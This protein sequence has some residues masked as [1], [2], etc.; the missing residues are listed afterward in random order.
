[1]YRDVRAAL[2][3]LLG[4]TLCFPT[5]AATTNELISAIQAVESVGKN[6]SQA[7]NAIQELNSGDATTLVPILNAMGTANPLALNWLQGAFESVASRSLVAGN[8]PKEQ[9]ET[10]VVERSNNAQARRLAYEWLVKVDPSAE[11]RLIP[12]M[13]DDPSTYLRRD[14][15]AYAIHQAKSAEA[16]QQREFWKVALNGAVDEDQVKEIA[17]ALKKLDSPV[18]LI[19]HFGYLMDWKLIG[20]F[21]NIEMKGFNVVYPP[22]NEIDLSAEYQGLKG[23]VKW[24][25]FHSDDP[26][27]LFDIAKLTESHKGAIDYAYTTFNSS[28]ERDLEF[29]LSIQNAF[30][31]WVNGELLFAREEYHRGMHFDQYIVAAHLHKGENVILLKVCQNEQDQDWAQDWSFTF[32]VCDSTGRAIQAA[33]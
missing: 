20:P 16:D 3:M 26:E 13:L 17:A 25:P 29:R 19:E 24:E 8:L 6:H 4:V 32:R 12:G 11:Q 2:A 7:V 5:L 9:L 22:E 27:G 15:V 1:M 21:D 14:A 30:K 18:N 10:F 23:A 31:I 33:R 28:E